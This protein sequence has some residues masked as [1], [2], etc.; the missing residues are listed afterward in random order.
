[1]SLYEKLIQFNS[2]LPRIWTER[3]ASHP[4]GWSSENPAYSQCAVTAALAQDVFGGEIVI[5][6]YTLPDGKV[7]QHYFN[8]LPNGRKI[9]FTSGQF[10]NGEEFNP[11]RQSSNHELMNKSRDYMKQAMSP[12]EFDGSMKEFIISAPAPEGHVTV[13]MRYRILRR[14]FESLDPELVKGIEIQSSRHRE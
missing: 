6:N 10:K 11:P 3:T 9:D 14:N 13:G 12:L 5:T 7:N 4:A 1:M 2:I 8:I